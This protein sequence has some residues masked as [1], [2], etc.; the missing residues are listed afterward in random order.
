MDDDSLKA[1]GAEAEELARAVDREDGALDPIYESLDFAIAELTVG[2]YQPSDLLPVGAEPGLGFSLNERRDGKTLWQAIAIAG[3]DSLCD[4]DSELRRRLSGE[5][6]M[7]ASALVALVMA[8]LGLPAIAIAIAIAVAGYI[9]AVGL[10]GF[11]NWA[12]A[13]PD[14]PPAA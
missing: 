9:L 12:K 3:R 14:G 8:S 1:A 11:C 6:N 7:S 2:G 4:S 13:E 10:P 5:G